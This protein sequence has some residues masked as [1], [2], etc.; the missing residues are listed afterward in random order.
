M[1]IGRNGLVVFVVLCGVVATLSIPTRAAE[2]LDG[3]LGGSVTSFAA[4]YGKATKKQGVYTYSVQ[5]FGLVAAGFLNEKA[6]EITVA[7]DRLKHTPLTTADD[8]D[9][10]LSVAAQIAQSLVPADSTYG[11]PVQSKES[12]TFVGKS[13]TLK[14]AFAQKD[15]SAL[16][17]AGKPGDFQV[18]YN[19][20]S[21]GNV[22]SVD[23]SIGSGPAAATVAKP[24]AT[25]TPKSGSGAT[26]TSSSSGSSNL[27]AAVHCSDFA[28]RADAQSYFDANGGNSNPKVATLDGDKDGRACQNL[29]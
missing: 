17:V 8:K 1:R 16:N 22:Y 2:S 27:V 5:G 4:E 28:T 6:H 19:L 13:A 3:H 20:D 11:D 29:P 24:T 14:P 25:K 18:I 26:S 23:I 21:K 10:S 15:L 9:W 7:A 12:I